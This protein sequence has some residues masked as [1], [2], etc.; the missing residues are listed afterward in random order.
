[1][2][3]N[4]IAA[5]RATIEIMERIA[6]AKVAAAIIKIINDFMIPKTNDKIKIKDEIYTIIKAEKH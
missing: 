2:K 4:K 5:A 1:M 3:R 6:K